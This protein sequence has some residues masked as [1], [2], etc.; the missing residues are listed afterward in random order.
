LLHSQA[1]QARIRLAIDAARQG[2]LTGDVPIGAVLFD[3]A[4]AVLAAACN[5]RE[6]LFDPTAHAEILVLRAAA[7]AAGN[8]NLAGTTLAVTTEPCT[9]CAGAIVLA[10]VAVVVFGCWEPKTGAAGSLWDVMRDRRLTHRVE[11]RGGVL[12]QECAA[13]LVDFFERLR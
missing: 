10:R 4:G 11:V 3:A 7:R 2:E 13:L 9:M 5:A 8:W 12:E 1:D 6:A